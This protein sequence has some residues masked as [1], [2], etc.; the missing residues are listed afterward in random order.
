MQSVAPS[1]F[2]L[3]NEDLNVNLNFDSFSKDLLTPPGRAR[4]DSA[5]S[6]SMSEASMPAIVQSKSAVAASQRPILPAL[7]HPGMSM[8]QGYM[9]DSPFSA[10]MASPFHGGVPSFQSN[11]NSNFS[12]PS[13]GLLTPSQFQSLMQQNTGYHMSQHLPDTPLASPPAPSTL[14]AS[15]WEE[16]AT[17]VIQ[18]E[19]KGHI[20]TRRMDNHRVN[21]TKLLNMTVSFLRDG[22]YF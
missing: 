8:T 12:Y 16:E 4:Q 17:N 11:T 20:V 22:V 10:D 6:I 7:I 2:D 3:S 21:G 13:P 15:F 14:F 1:S 5:V 19:F 18:M 9:S